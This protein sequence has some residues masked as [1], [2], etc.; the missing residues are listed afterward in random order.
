MVMRMARIKY[1][2]PDA[3]DIDNSFAELL[4]VVNLDAKDTGGAIKF[5]GS[6][7]VVPSKHRL[8]TIMAFGMMGAAAAV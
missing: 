4:R 6:D 5:T 2:S 1:D 8:G 7:P 3:F